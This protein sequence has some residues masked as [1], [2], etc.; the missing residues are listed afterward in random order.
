MKRK[1]NLQCTGAEFHFGTSSKKCNTKEE[2]S[3]HDL[4]NHFPEFT[5]ERL[6]CSNSGKTRENQGAH[7]SAEWQAPVSAERQWCPMDA[8]MSRG[9]SRGGQRE[10]GIACA[11]LFSARLHCELPCVADAAWMLIEQ[12]TGLAS[13]NIS[14]PL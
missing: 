13:L 5:P 2:K 14:V 11:I 8:G 3:L 6:H 7:S 1:K 9:I 4:Q 10:H 12:L